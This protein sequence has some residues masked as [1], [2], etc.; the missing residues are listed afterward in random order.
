[1][2]IDPHWKKDGDEMGKLI[3]GVGQFKINNDQ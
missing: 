3:A 1:M 2:T